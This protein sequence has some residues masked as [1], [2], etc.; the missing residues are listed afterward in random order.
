[1]LTTVLILAGLLVLSSLTVGA[2]EMLIEYIKH[3]WW[4]RSMKGL[5]AD[6]RAFHKATDT[7]IRYAPVFPA[8]DRV[9][10]RVKLIVEE[11]EEFTNAVASYDIIE[12]ADALA[13][14]IYV[15]VGT[16]LE[17][18]IPLDKVWDEV[19][20]S[21]MSKLDPATGKAIKRHDGKVLKGPNFSPPDIQRLLGG[22]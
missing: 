12:V 10:L 18:G 17:F 8:N 15:A 14:L 2:V 11:A 22:V 21:N 5:L 1:M 16:A 3:R 4:H 19:Q 20:R 6:V 13:D 9:V 7:P